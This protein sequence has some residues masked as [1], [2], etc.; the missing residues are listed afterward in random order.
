MK[1]EKI[2]KFQKERLREGHQRKKTVKQVSGG[3]GEVS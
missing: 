2:K 3:G 1:R